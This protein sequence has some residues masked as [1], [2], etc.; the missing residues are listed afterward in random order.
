[1]SAPE[2]LC[3]PHPR[4]AEI[5][6]TIR[7]QIGIDA[8]LAV[9]ARQPRWWTNSTGDVVF[10]FRFGS[11]YGLAKWIEITYTVADDYDVVAYKIRRNGLRQT[12][13]APDQYAENGIETCEWDGVYFDDLPRLVRRANLLAELS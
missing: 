12:I 2:I 11:R 1:M 4:G 8:W 9:S 10:S 3:A 5:A 7:S 13:T 6:R